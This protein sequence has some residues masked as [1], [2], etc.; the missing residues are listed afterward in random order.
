MSADPTWNVVVFEVAVG[1]TLDK[2][3]G[4]APT[5]SAQCVQTVWRELSQTNRVSPQAVQQLY[6][7]WEPSAEDKAFIE[8]TFNPQI[9]VTFSFARPAD[10]NWDRALREAAQKIDKAVNTPVKSRKPW[11]RFWG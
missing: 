5:R 7:E 9:R 6:S 3:V 1:R 11:W 2:L 10:G 4:H 8:A